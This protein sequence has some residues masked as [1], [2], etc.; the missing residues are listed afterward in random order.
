MKYKAIISIVTITFL[1]GCFGLTTQSKF[2]KVPATPAEF[3]IDTKQPNDINLTCNEIGTQYRY[4]GMYSAAI[5]RAFDPKAPV[6]MTSSSYTTT[7]GFT[8]IYGNTAATSMSSN[9]YGGGTVMVYESLTLRSR[10]IR[11]SIEKRQAELKHL[12]NRQG[13]CNADMLEASNRL[14]NNLKG[15]LE[16]KIREYEN[17]SEV[18]NYNLQ[19]SKTNNWTPSQKQQLS[20]S[21]KEHQSTG[22][23]EVQ[24]LKINYEEILK[25]HRI[26]F[27]EAEKEALAKRNWFDRN[28]TMN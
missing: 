7:S 24:T 11:R 6:A 22:N 9:T 10:D 25:E 15:T 12:S 14:L 23:K 26:K 18:L 5:D 13:N 28:T 21:I 19:I 17:N 2:P 16:S 27:E 3:L 1:S 20:Q 8:S 4:L